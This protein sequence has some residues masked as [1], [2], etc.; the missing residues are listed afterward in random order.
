MTD[1][2]ALPEQRQALIH[3]MLI[4]T[5]R[6]IGV[7]VARQLGVSEHTIRRDLQEL[8][9]KGLCKKVYGGAVSQ[10]KQSASFETRVAENV[11]EK[12]PIAR[13]C[14]QMIKPGSCIFIDSGSTYLLMVNFIPHEMELTIVTNSPQI[15]AALSSRKSGEL[16]MLG[17]KVNP[18][19]GSALGSETVNQ[20]RNMLFDQAFIGVCG[21]DPQAGLSAAYYDDACFKKEVFNQSNEVIAAVTA[22][23]ISQV[24]RYK[25]A[26]CE[27]IDIVVAST[28]TPTHSFRHTSL[29]FEVAE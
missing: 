23:K 6:V 9:R 4:D 25:V 21:L 1:Y 29:R 10:L 11:E 7:D 5:G 18:L 12:E 2:N 28:Q 27:E 24:A 14:A 8:A 16:I 22:D 20:L 15:A 13:R 26:G 3:Q 19:V 17:G